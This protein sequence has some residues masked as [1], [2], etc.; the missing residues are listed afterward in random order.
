MFRLINFYTF[1]LALFM[2]GVVM[3]ATAQQTIGTHKDLIQEQIFLSTDKP[4]YLCGEIM[5]LGIKVMDATS[6]QLIDMSKVAYVEI[7]NQQNTPVLQSKIKIENGNGNGSLSLPFSLATG[8]YTIR[9]YTNWMKNF[10]PEFFFSKTVSIVNT[11]QDA[12]VAVSQNK[13]LATAYFFPEGGAMVHGISSVIGVK[14]LDEKGKGIDAKGILLNDKNDTVASFSTLKYG[15]GRF[16][17]TPEKG[18]HYYAKIQLNNGSVIQQ[19]LPEALNEG[20]VFSLADNGNV[21][22][23]TYHPTEARNTGSWSVVLNNEPN[24]SF[25]FN[26][27]RTLSIRKDQLQEGVNVITLMNGKDNAV[28][29][30]L[31]FIQP[32]KNLAVTAKSDLTSYGK[33]SKVNATISTGSKN[34]SPAPADIITTVY[35]IDGLTDM[36][37]EH[38]LSSLWLDNH[39]KGKIEDPGFYFNPLNKNSSEVFDNLMITQ[40][41]RKIVK[42]S[43]GTI[44]NA[45]EYT[46]HLITGRVLDNNNQPV[47]GVNVLLSVPGDRIQTK[48]SQ[49]DENGFIFFPMKDFYG[50]NQ[51]VIQTYPQSAEKL[52]IE[53]R[54]PFFEAVTINQT[55]QVHTVF[56]PN[57]LADNHLKMQVQNVY[58]ALNSFLKPV[59][60]TIPFYYKPYKSYN[61]SDYV[62]FTKM[63]EVMREYVFEVNVRKS[64]NNFRFMTFNNDGFILKTLQE[65][66]LMLPENP[67]VF[68]DGIPVFDINRIIHYDPLKVKKLDIVASRYYLGTIKMDGILSYHT[69]N[70]SLEGFEPSPND[71]VM[72]Y[73]GIQ[74][75][76]VFYSPVYNSSEEK[77]SRIPDFRSV[78]YWNPSLESDGNAQINFFT[79]DWKGKYLVRVQA[80]GK[81]G[82]AGQQ[83]FVIN[84]D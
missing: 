65:T 17:L 63:E 8:Q 21:I 81:D 18:Q 9:A 72:E 64:G 76:R 50:S 35:K 16:S 15:M 3:P 68:L 5:W 36:S 74:L 32:E 53:I 34:G 7:L 59:L 60:D 58:H 56:E 80:I 79:G 47:K 82:S 20:V 40:G 78:L 83:S 57:H 49:S 23:L 19:I 11:T 22:S 28:A 46:G 24:S 26:Q 30:R 45:P 44:T 61:L 25:T 70:A 10:S 66:V 31:F 29:E 41:W 67:M 27:S 62:R 39:V 52:N 33:R 38:I 6:H 71:R 14:I 69:Y 13:H 48:V 55:D 54:S 75:E 1:L 37:E 2:V 51:I 73:E 43:G 4:A 77:Q 12:E 42:S 84:V